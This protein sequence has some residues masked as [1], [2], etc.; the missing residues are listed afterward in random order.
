MGDNTPKLQ[1]GDDI[2]IAAVSQQTKELTEAEEVAQSNELA[3]TLTSLQSLIE[4]NAKR[5]N[6][7]RQDLREKRESL[8]SV[9]DNDGQLS[10]AQEE[11]K[12]YDQKV[13]ERRVQISNDPQAV[14]LRNDIGELNESKKDL[15]MALSDHLVNYYQ[16]TNSTSFDTSDGDQWEFKIT[17][18]VKT[19]RK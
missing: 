13:R 2:A 5:I 17:A 16:L 3:D 7:V 11:L 18:K 10:G 9:Y 14:T 19:Q 4:R 6:Q 1:T 15:E 8:K 12:Q